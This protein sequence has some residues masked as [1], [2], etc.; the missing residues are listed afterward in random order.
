MHDQSENR[1]VYIKCRV[2]PEEYDYI[3]QKMKCAGCSTMS[4]YLRKMAISGLIVRYDS[5]LFLDL[6]RRL[7]SV[8]NNINQI[9][10]RVNQ[11]DSLYQDDLLELKKKVNEIWRTLRSIQSTLRCEKQ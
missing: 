1:T 3:L 8:A 6:Q 11:S 10:I 7:H 2:T 5:Q 9:A 4:T